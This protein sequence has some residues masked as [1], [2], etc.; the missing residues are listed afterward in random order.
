VQINILSITISNLGTVTWHFF[1]KKITC[2][3]RHILRSNEVK[4][5]V[6]DR[7]VASLQVKSTL[8]LEYFVT[9]KR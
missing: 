1:F 7:K 5:Q 4:V 2:N 3:D 8:E 9:F 6:N